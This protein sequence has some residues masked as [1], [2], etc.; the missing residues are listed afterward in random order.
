MGWIDAETPTRYRVAYKDGRHLR[1][2]WRSKSSVQFVATE[3]RGKVRNHSHPTLAENPTSKG[4]KALVRAAQRSEKFF[5]MLPR[6]VRRVNIKMPRALA[7]LGHCSQVNYVNDKFD[8]KLREYFHQFEGPTE[9][10]VGDSPQPDGSELIIIKGKFR[11][12][13]E[14]ITG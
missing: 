6:E 4:K 13:A 7:S 9:I 2:V 12:E 3:K 1:T 5:Q 14:G 8:G 10:F 11:I